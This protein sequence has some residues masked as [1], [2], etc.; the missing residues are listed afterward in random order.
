MYKSNRRSKGCKKKGVSGAKTTKWHVFT[1]QIYSD[2]KIKKYCFNA[3]FVNSV[4]LKISPV[5]M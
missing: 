5:K 4:T 3:Y 1:F 2:K